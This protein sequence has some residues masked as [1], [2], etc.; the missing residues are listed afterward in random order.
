VALTIPF[1]T[2]VGLACKCFG[3][4]GIGYRVPEKPPYANWD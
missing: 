4:R 1:A 2:L 3:E